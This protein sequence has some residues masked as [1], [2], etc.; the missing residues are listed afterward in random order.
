MNPPQT[1]T[2]L[3]AH[4]VFFALHDHADA[5]RERLVRACQTH[6]AG[7]PGILFFA[8]GTRAA[9]LRREVNDQDFDVALH[10]LFRDQAAHDH[11]QTTP[12]HLRFLD[13]N[14]DNW[15]RVRVFDSVVA[16]CPT[17]AP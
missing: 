15:R 2:G 3:L 9:E 16:Q 7:H 1:G 14:R 10:I 5:A 12:A 4:N 6:L 13:E 17:P 8:C 11:Y